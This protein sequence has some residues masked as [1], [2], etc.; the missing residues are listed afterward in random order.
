MGRLNRHVIDN[1]DIEVNPSDFPVEFNSEYVPDIDT[2]I[3]KQIDDD[4]MD[5]ILELF[6]SEYDEDILSVE[7]QML[8]AWL[9][10]APPSKFYTLS[11]V[12]FHKYRGEKVA[13]KD[14]MSHFSMFVSTKSTVKMANRNTGHTQGVGIILC[15]FPNFSLIYPVGPVHYFP[16]H[17]SNTISSGA[18]KCWFSKDYF[19]NYWTLWICWPSR[20]FLGI[21]L[22]DSKQY[23]LSSNRN[24]QSQP[25]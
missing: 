6:H 24:F 17:P 20:L 2:T 10:V 8:Q 5:H 9:V 16:G 19:W 13:V 12:L 18:L 1:G 11:T 21:T 22:L 23:W 3:I 4:W 14:C 25:S 7:I 15:R